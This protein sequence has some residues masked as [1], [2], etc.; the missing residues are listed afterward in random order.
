MLGQHSQLGQGPILKQVGLGIHSPKIS[1]VSLLQNSP[2]QH[3]PMQPQPGAQ[4]VQAAPP[5]FAQPFSGQIAFRPS[6]PLGTLHPVGL[7]APSIRPVPGVRNFSVHNQQ[8]GEQNDDS[9]S[10]PDLANL[11]E[12]RKTSGLTHIPVA[13]SLVAFKKCAPNSQLSKDQ[14]L[15]AYQQELRK[16]GVPL[17]DMDTQ[18]KVF[19]LFDRDNNDVVDMMELICGISLLCQGAED[20]KIQAVFSI[21]DENNNGFIT[22]DEMFKF[23]SSVYKVVLTPKVTQTMKQMGVEAE[24]AEDLASVTCLACFKAADLNNDG[25]LSLDEFKNWFYGTQDG[26]KTGLSPGS[27]LLY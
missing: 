2:M 24:S 5:M 25:K 18:N 1:N 19:A 20:D 10:D 15:G 12:L 14:F 7:R 27:R 21:F 13:S 26:P 6:G 4:P 8:Y 22:M 11:R 3:I 23:L 16:Y 9:L 17:P